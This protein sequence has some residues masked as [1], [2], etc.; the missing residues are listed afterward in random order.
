MATD[1]PCPLARRRRAPTY[2][3][4]PLREPLPAGH[5]VAVGPAS[6]ER[7]KRHGSRWS[8]PPDE[9]S[10]PMALGLLGLPWA[11]GGEMG[12]LPPQPPANLDQAA[13]SIPEPRG[14]RRRRQ[15]LTRLF[16][17]TCITKSAERGRPDCAHEHQ[18]EAQNAAVRLGYGRLSVHRL[19]SR[20]G[21]WKS[22]GGTSRCRELLQVAR[23]PGFSTR[24]AAPGRPPGAALPVRVRRPRLRGAP[25][26]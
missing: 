20:L 10:W 26:P 3:G 8:A 2:K 6:G 11:D 14:P 15:V 23:S 5:P 25:S 13:E 1:G 4:E 22:H 16:F 21:P 17:R 24:R 18:R 19:R 7:G 12:R 9:R